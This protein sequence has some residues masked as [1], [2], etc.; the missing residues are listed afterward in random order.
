MTEVK[1]N[2]SLPMIMYIIATCLSAFSVLFKQLYNNVHFNFSG[3]N[4]RGLIYALVPTL[5]MTLLIVHGA[6]FKANKTRIFFM[7]YY[8]AQFLIIVYTIYCNLRVIFNAP[9]AAALFFSYGDVVYI[10]LYALIIIDCIA[11][12]KHAMARTALILLIVCN[13]LFTFINLGTTIVYVIKNLD[14]I[15][16]LGDLGRYFGGGFSFAISIVSGVFSRASFLLTTIAGIIYTSKDKPAQKEL[17]TP[18]RP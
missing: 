10:V 18:L 17:A 12:K 15:D 13:V 8:I 4:V 2:S 6:M 9:A 5:L 1:R 3:V 7:L 11:S 16:S 14:Y